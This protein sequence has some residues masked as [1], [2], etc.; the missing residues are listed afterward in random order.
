MTADRARRSAVLNAAAKAKSKAKTSAAEQAIRTLVKRGEAVTFQAV[1]REAG[2]SH[3]FL[4]G[5]E[6]LRR[7]IQHLRDQA[8]PAPQQR[9][10]GPDTV[11]LALTN[12][13]DQLKKRHRD[14]VQALRTALEQAHGENLLLRR[15]LT[16][17]G[18]AA[19]TG[20][21]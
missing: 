13:I 3:A 16:R 12:Q 20:A 4:Y 9:T 17:R 21:N 18:T 19:G 5:H 7:R 14:E 2:V 8:R 10:D 11:V 15:E 1:C 6:D